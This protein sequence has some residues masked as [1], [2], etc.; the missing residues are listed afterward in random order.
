MTLDELIQK[1]PEPFR[2]V[3]AE[4]GPALLAMSADELWRWIGLLA[5][6]DQDAAYRE[7]LAKMPGAKLVA[8]WDRVNEK[9][10]EANAENAAAKALGKRAMGAVLGALLTVVLALVG[11]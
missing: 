10:N 7:V 6:G 2:P 4:Y 8:E 3:A 1:V 11:L 9:W 5:K